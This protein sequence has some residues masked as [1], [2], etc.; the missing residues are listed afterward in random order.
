MV[1]CSGKRAGIR[2]SA[3]SL[4][5][6]SSLHDL[7]QVSSPCECGFSCV[8]NEENEV[9][10]DDLTRLVFVGYSSSQSTTHGDTLVMTQ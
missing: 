1:Q 2:S 7:E 8:S 10:P 5:S 9:L 4:G 6:A 3:V